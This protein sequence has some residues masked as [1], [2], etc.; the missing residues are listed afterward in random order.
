[1]HTTVRRKIAAALLTVTLATAFAG[2]AAADA[3]FAAPTDVT[4]SLLPRDDGSV[5]VSVNWL[6][7]RHASDTDTGDL[8]GFRVRLSGSASSYATVAGGTTTFTRGAPDAAA[9]GTHSAILVAPA[10]AAGPDGLLHVHVEA[11]DGYSDSSCG[12]AA[13]LAVVFA[14][15]EAAPV[16]A[17]DPAGAPDVIRDYALEN[18]PVIVAV[19]GAAFLV[20]LTFW[21]MRRGLNRSRNAMRL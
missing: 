14:A 1:M 21:L 19:V 2:P 17:D 8:S 12:R 5:I 4:A 3:P 9:D 6:Y 15:A 10:D 7:R 20:G 16:D 13:V 11:C 18:A